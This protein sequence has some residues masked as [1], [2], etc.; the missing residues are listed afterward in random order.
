MIGNFLQTVFAFILV[1]APLVFIHEL[2]HFL[3]AKAF[4]IGVPVFSLGF[5]PRLW[6][7]KRA[8]TDYRL[9]LVPLGGYVRLAGDEA[10]ENRTGAPEEFLSRP[11]YQRFIVFVAGA[12]F[13]VILAFLA[14]WLFFGLYGKEAVAYPVVQAIAEDSAASRS[15]VQVGDTILSINGKDLVENDS[16]QVLSLDLLLSP[17]QER[18]I[19]LERAGQRVVTT[20]FTGED[21][22]F[23][24]GIPGWR[25][26]G[27]DEVPTL[28]EVLP[29]SPAEAAGLQADDVIVAAGG[30]DE[31]GQ[32]ELRQMIQQAP[33]MAID[34]QVDRAGERIALTVT[35][36]A[37]DDGKGVIGVHFV[38]FE[39]PRVSLSVGQAAA[40]SLRQNIVLSKTLFVVLKRLVTREVSVRS[41]S[42][43]IGIAQVANS[44]LEQ[45]PR[46]FLY[47]LAFFSLQL[48]I[49]N[50][51]P[52]PVLD[53]G[54]I[55]I[56]FVEGILRRDLPEIVKERVMQ[57]GFVFLLAF[58][59]L[60][61][62]LDIVKSV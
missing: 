30:Q 6:G 3:A 32:L 29:G 61:V 53:G 12:A 8:E 14:F 38:P 36:R 39:A 60:I 22:K 15:G 17:N 35:P 51:L 34:L 52:I 1:L 33:G 16:N 50:L 21:P 41:M 20:M 40:E 19:V 57:A 11:K 10:D 37:G 46:V 44:A 5:G 31:I 59:G 58:M 28:L 56:L 55:L 47:L 2:G 7:F 9:S 54:H 23:K 26:G 27:A 25:L 49:L 62:V 42:G 18:E 48:G 45:G 43:P 4:R 24:M 13:N